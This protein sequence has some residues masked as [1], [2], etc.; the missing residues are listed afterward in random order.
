MTLCAFSIQ[1]GLNPTGIAPRVNP[2]NPALQNSLAFRH[3]NRRRGG[4][5]AN[6]GRYRQEL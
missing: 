2:T 5:V 3:R 1:T 6:R 4:L